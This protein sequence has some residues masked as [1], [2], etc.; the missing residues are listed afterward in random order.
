MPYKEKTMKSQRQKERRKGEAPTKLKPQTLE[1]PTKVK[2]LSE[3]PKVQMVT[4]QFGTRPWFLK[5]SDE[6]LC[7]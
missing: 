1:V 7:L 5:L 2:P 6:T 3:A 4:D